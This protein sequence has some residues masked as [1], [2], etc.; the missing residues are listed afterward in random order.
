[1]E[2][3]LKVSK[4]Q[5][6]TDLGKIRWHFS[7]QRA[8]NYATKSPSFHRED[9]IEKMHTTNVS[10]AEQILDYELIPED[11]IQSKIDYFITPYNKQLIYHKHM[12]FG[13]SIL[14]S[15]ELLRV[16]NGEDIHHDKR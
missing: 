9:S 11:Q 5:I 10:I 12:D 4:N 13:K 1:M 7:T 2:A 6:A 15:E 8:R 16:M 3:N 14:T